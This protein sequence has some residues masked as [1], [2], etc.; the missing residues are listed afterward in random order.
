MQYKEDNNIEKVINI[1]YNIKKA[2]YYFPI[3]IY[4]IN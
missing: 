3:F 2:T 1:N 4:S